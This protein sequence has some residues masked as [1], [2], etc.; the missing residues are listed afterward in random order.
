MNDMIEYWLPRGVIALILSLSLTELDIYVRVGCAV[1]V[2]ISTIIYQ[3]RKKAG[4]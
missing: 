3:H 4:Q 2:A 1:A